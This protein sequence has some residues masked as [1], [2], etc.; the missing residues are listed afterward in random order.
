M[1]LSSFETRQ[2]SCPSSSTLLKTRQGRQRSRLIVLASIV[3]RTKV[4]WKNP[5]SDE[6]R[7]PDFTDGDQFDKMWGWINTD[8]MIQS[9]GLVDIPM[10]RH[11]RDSQQLEVDQERVLFLA[12]RQAV[13]DRLWTRR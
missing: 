12:M 1:R 6:S 3:G 9:P 8:N 7:W 13:G 2:L 11:G 10:L 5:S 4:N